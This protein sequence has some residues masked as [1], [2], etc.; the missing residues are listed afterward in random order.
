[1]CGVPNFPN[2]CSP[3]FQQTSRTGFVFS[4]GIS[5]TNVLTNDIAASS[6]TLGAALADDS[7]EHYGA[8]FVVFVPAT[9][10]GTYTVDFL[11]A[12]TFLLNGAS[13]NIPYSSIPAEIEILPPSCGDGL[14][15]QAAETC[16][17][18]ADTLCNACGSCRSAG[19]D[20]CTCCGDGVLQS[21]EECDGAAGS[22][23]SGQVCSAECHCEVE[24][25]CS[26]D[27]LTGNCEPVI[28]DGTIVNTDIPCNSF[29]FH[30]DRI[31]GIAVNQNGQ[32]VAFW[33]Q[34][35]DSPDYEVWSSRTSDAGTTWHDPRFMFVLRDEFSPSVLAAGASE[36]V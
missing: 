34:R 14:L 5:G 8:T 4:G 12:G 2:Q 1:V 21:G 6:L 11:P 30:N 24:P 35:E 17:S 16:D 29:G 36:R 18:D 10:A 26:C 32:G 9:A 33:I 27:P 13:E 7:T 28:R 19:A 31:L 15:N 23:P 20:A 22:C 25:A 3:A